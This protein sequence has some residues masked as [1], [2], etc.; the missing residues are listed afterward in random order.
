VRIISPFIQIYEKCSE[1]KGFA[2]G[3]PQGGPIQQLNIWSWRRKY[4]GWRVYTPL[5]K[6]QA[7][8]KIEAEH[9]RRR[10]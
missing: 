2:A 5:S 6:T 8:A 10:K 9:L 7:A 4:L 1:V 3:W